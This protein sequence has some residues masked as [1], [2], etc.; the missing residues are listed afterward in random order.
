MTLSDTPLRLLVKTYANGLVNRDQ[1]LDIR[2]ELLRKLSAHG[3]ISHED[4]QNF[5]NIQLDTRKPSTITSYSLSDWII[6]L[7][8]LIAAA[9][10]G[11]LL[12][13]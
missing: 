5:L 2:Q 13:S 6:I 3:E 4:L 1:Y 12:Y 9:V 10:L 11:F 8:G 7:L